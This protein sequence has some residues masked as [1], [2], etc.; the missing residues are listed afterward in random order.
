[1]CYVF[2]RN[3]ERTAVRKVRSSPG[4][5]SS[6]PRFIRGDV[7]ADANVQVGRS[8]QVADI[9]GQG[10][11]TNSVAPPVVAD[12]PA[13]SWAPPTQPGEVIFLMTYLSVYDFN[14]FFVSL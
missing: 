6:S 12:A 2:P 13:I 7:T 9:G 11:S 4:P 14:T 1:M 10:T 3:R 8:D 5:T